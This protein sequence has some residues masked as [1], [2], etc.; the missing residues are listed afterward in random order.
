M[1]RNPRKNAPST[2]RT[3]R[4]ALHT[5]LERI[6]GVRDGQA[7][8]HLLG[9]RRGRGR[10]LRRRLDAQ[11]CPL[12]GRRLVLA[13]RH[14]VRELLRLWILY[15]GAFLDAHALR[16]PRAVSASRARAADEPGLNASKLRARRRLQVA[17]ARMRNR[18]RPMLTHAGGVNAMAVL[19]R[20]LD[21]PRCLRR[22]SGGRLRGLPHRSRGDG[23]G[24][25]CV[26]RPLT[27]TAGRGYQCHTQS[28]ESDEPGVAD[29]P[30]RPVASL[31][32]SEARQPAVR[33]GA[34]SRTT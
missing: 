28:D 13:L 19:R 33:L 26:N 15:G 9:L 21:V 20:L 14:A 16:E 25:G 27:A 17:C 32:S 24:R 5:G 11:A 31:L 30:Q 12:V 34:G 8:G 2:A 18:L 22:P 4:M 7:A 23:R 1:R 29:S 6:Q 3:L 10:R